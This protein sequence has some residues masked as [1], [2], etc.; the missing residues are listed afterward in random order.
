MALNLTNLWRKAVNYLQYSNPIT[1]TPKIVNGVAK[2]ASS[3]EVQ[4]WAVNFMWWINDTMNFPAY[5]VGKVW[6]YLS[7][8]WSTTQRR[9]DLLAKS[10][11]QASDVWQDYNSTAYALWR[12]APALAAA[13]LAPVAAA[14]AWTLTAVETAW[15]MAPALWWQEAFWVWLPSWEWD[16]REDMRQEMLQQNTAQQ[17]DEAKI[18]IVNELKRMI[19]AWEVNSNPAR[20][21]ALLNLYNKIK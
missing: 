13:P 20:A 8:Q 16:R 10:A 14:P 19:G 18:K 3:P 15:I 17:L 5:A 2:I 9:F 11:R 21:Q 12:M 1:A 6:A 7:P 4:Q